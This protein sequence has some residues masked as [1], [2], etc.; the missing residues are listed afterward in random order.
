MRMHDDDHR[1]GLA[2]HLAQAIGGI[3]GAIAGA[4]IGVTA[5]AIGIVL[6]GIAG[7]IGGWWI[8]RA[9]VETAAD[10]ARDGERS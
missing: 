6:G 1:P 4:A 5:G 10:R 8:G 9:I 2:D 7:A 3:T